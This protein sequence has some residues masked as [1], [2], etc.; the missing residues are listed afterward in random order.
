M[1]VFNE[2]RGIYKLKGG[3]RII[4]KNNIEFLRAMKSNTVD[5]IYIDPPFNTG[6]S[7]VRVTENKKLEYK[8]A[9]MN[10]SQFIQDRMVEAYRILKKDGSLLFHIDYREAPTCRFILD[11]LFGI[12][13]LMNEIIWHYDYGGR[14]KKFHPRKHDNIYWYVKDV[15]NYTYNYDAIDRIPYMSELS[16]QTYGE[17]RF[18]KGKVPT[19]VWFQTIVQSTGMDGEKTGYPTQKPIKLL[20]RLIKIHSNKNDRVMDFF[21]GSGTT[22]EACL[23]LDRK[24]LLIDSNPD[25]IK[26]MLRRFKS[27][28]MNKLKLG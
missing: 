13:N 7:Q 17:E 24:F 3:N 16:K 22:G 19:D 27:K 4:Y 20:S 25:A 8:D 1:L 26:I 10:Y 15:E 21:A 6:R 2:D 28:D 18:N 11:R 14:S 9:F 5:L 12:N 23:A